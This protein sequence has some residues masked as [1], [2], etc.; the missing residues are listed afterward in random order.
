M[1]QKWTKEKLEKFSEEIAT[2]FDEGKIK[3]PI[4]LSGGKNQAESLIRIF[5]DF[6]KGD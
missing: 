3:F 6:N 4:H 5:S 2:L 1:K